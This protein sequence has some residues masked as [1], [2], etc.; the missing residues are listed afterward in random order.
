MTRW[1]RWAFN[2]LTLAVTISGFAYLWMRYVIQS[3][4]PFAVVNHPWQST[5]LGLHVLVSPLLLLTFGVIFRSHILK[6]LQTSQQVSNRRSGLTALGTFAAM[7]RLGL[8]APGGDVRRVAHG[9]A[10][11]ARGQRL[12]VHPRLRWASADQLR[13]AARATEGCRAQRSVTRIVALV[14]LSLAGCSALFTPAPLDP[15]VRD[16]YLMGTR[17]RLTSYAR[18]RA[19]GLARLED[20]LS[21]LEATEQELSTWVDESAISRLNHWPVGDPWH[22]AGSLCGL[23]S[24]LYTLRS[25]TGGAF[26]PA[27]GTLVDAWD[28]HGVGRVPTAAE[29]DSALGHSSLA[30]LAF[31]HASCNLTRTTPVMIDVGAFG[32]GRGTRPNRPRSA[33]LVRG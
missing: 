5:M 22:A 25:M 6:K 27:V 11:R 4:D 16:V 23:F 28:L 33:L 10:R 3:D 14:L 30:Q 1:E 26:D 24:K 31:D 20:A 32:K 7:E 17:A 8:P 21:V 13:N 19:Q 12:V 15:V 29:I 18:T 9:A 2:G